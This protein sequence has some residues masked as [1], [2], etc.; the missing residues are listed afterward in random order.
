M[1]TDYKLLDTG[2]E[3][4][5]EQFGEVTLVRTAK[6]AMWNP[7][8]DRSEWQKA[9]AVYTGDKWKGE[10]PELV[11]HFDDV[12]FSIG[13]LEAGQ[14]GVFP[15]QEE[16][17]EWLRSITKDKS[18]KIINGFAY[19]GGSTF[20]S[21]NPIND[22]THLDAS[23]PS[24]V[25]AMHNMELS[26]MSN[27][28]IRFIVDDV[29][30]FLQKE[31]KR[32]NKYDGFIFDP[33]A[34]GRGGKGKTWKLSK[35]LPTLIQ[36]ISELSDGKP[37]FVLLSAHD[38]SMDHRTLAEH[39]KGLCPKGTVIEKGKFIMKPV[40]GKTMENGYFARFCV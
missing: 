3:K 29:I 20:F 14:V 17:W 8:L 30:T 21:S 12:L 31:V 15:E 34:F 28:K 32:G 38:P 6:Q 22:V 23:K 25:K 13:L 37:S 9:D 7:T 11:T 36:L 5:L 35:D 24:V 18:H 19:T 2:N 39:M 40:N 4:R 10:I 16:S 27:H 1:K 33:P 26:R